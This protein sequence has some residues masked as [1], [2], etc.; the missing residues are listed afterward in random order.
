MFV[1]RVMLLW[2]WLISIIAISVFDLPGNS[3]T[4][5]AG[6]GLMFLP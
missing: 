5:V 2:L 6:P 1:L 4:S 3:A